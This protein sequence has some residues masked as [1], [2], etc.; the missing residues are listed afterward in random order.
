MKDKGKP[1][2]WAYRVIGTALF[3]FVCSAVTA[4]GNEVTATLDPAQ[5]SVGESAQL[6]VT[7]SGSESATPSL[8]AVTGLDFQS[9]GQSTQIQVINGAMTAES[10]HTYLVTPRQAGTFTIPPIEAGG[11]KSNP[12]TLRV[13]A[14]SGAARPAQQGTQASSGSSL[15]PPNVNIAPVSVSA[16]EDARFGFMQIAV[17]KKEFYVGELVPVEVR[18]YFPEGLQASVTG[19][20][21][22]NSEAF[23]LSKLDQLERTEKVVNRRNFMVLT[24][25]S[26]ISAVKAG[27]YS[28]GAQMPATIV[29][30]EQAERRS[31][32]LLDDFFDNPAFGFGGGQ[33]KEVTLQSAPDAVKVMPLPAAGRP[34]NFS[35]GVGKF[36]VEATAS[37][38][39]A[40]V[41]DPITLTLKIT[42]SGNFDRISTDMIPSGGRLENLQAEKH[43]RTSGQRR[44]SGHEDSRADPHSQRPCAHRNPGD[45]VQFFRS[46]DGSV[47][48]AL[49]QAD[50]VNGDRNNRESERRAGECEFVETAIG[51]AAGAGSRPE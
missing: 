30:R 31:G 49:D 11:A 37:T 2:G 4:A 16:P 22:L 32:S 36:D 19:L 24:W 35:G 34:K 10:A 12:M 7:V 1:Q 3:A 33:Q 25:H 29:V 23:T 9:V 43:F 8:P 44:L 14:N 41:G 5:V 38:D 17:P 13:L 20:P 18:A 26:A 45:F 50:S 51:Y 40:A 39:K 28:L 15:P 27:D 46:R 42:G 48:H 6:T 21:T 47:C